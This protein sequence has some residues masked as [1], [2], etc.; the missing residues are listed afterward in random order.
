MGTYKFVLTVALLALPGYAQPVDRQAGPLRGAYVLGPDDVIGIRVA[1][2][3]EMTDKS[4]RIGPNGSINLPMVG[5]VQ[6][7]GLTAEELEK[8]LA[9]RLK[10]FIRNPSVSVNVVVIDLADW[11]AT[12]RIL[13]LP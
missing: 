2:A 11:N 6:A 12:R 10:P 3:E 5:R 4:I 13:I 1:D 9:A 7:G 8:D